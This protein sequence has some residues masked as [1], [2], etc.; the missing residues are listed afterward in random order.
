MQ[1]CR[2]CETADYPRKVVKVLMVV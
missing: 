1:L 2:F